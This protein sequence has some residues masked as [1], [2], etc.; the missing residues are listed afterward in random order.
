MAKNSLDVAW[1]LS[2]LSVFNNGVLH[3]YAAMLLTKTAI[4]D[5]ECSGN[6]IRKLASVYPHAA[7]RA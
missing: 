7:V 1:S 2:E 6:P 5:V 3:R 4:S